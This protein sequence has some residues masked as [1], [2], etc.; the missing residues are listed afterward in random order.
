MG[1][2][3]REEMGWGIGDSFAKMIGERWVR[4]SGYEWGLRAL[5]LEIE[6]SMAMGRVSYIQKLLLYLA[7]NYAKNL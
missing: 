7:A 1:V 4:I 2:R 6:K 3:R 5:C